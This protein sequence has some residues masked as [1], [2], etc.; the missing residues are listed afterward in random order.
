[1]DIKKYFD[2]TN[3]E[4][5]E[6]LKKLVDDSIPLSCYDIADAYKLVEKELK[7]IKENNWAVDF[8]V[9]KEISDFIATKTN[10]YN[11]FVGIGCSSVVANI[12]EITT[13]DLNPIE[14]GLIFERAFSPKTWSKTLFATFGF[15][16]ENEIFDEVIKTIKESCPSATLE[17]D[18]YSKGLSILTLKDIKIAI[19]ESVSSIQEN[20]QYLSNLK[21]IKTYG[22]FDEDYMN[23]L[24][25]CFGLSY[26]E[27][28]DFRKICG[29]KK[30]EE[31]EEKKNKLLEKIEKLYE[32]N[33][34]EKLL[35][36]IIKDF[37]FTKSK[38][39]YMSK[40]LVFD[41]IY[42]F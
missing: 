41:D 1:M 5:F 10:L 40:C 6:C 15:Y 29:K 18:K 25:F 9:A 38:A 13:E 39:V 22:S 11:F 8:L 3:E 4:Q 12:I 24:H 35:E 7:V 32:R 30:I 36:T 26:E 23:L 37:C 27:T 42:P 17:K 20:A 16:V 34:K 19:Y 14:N 2:M 31:I 28:N 33:E 21:N